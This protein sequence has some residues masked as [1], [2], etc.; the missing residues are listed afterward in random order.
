MNGDAHTGALAPHRLAAGEKVGA[1]AADVI[2]DQADEAERHGD[3][4]DDA[5]IEL[6]EQAQGG[7][8]RPPQEDERQQEQERQLEDDPPE[9]RRWHLL[10]GG[11]RVR[12][13]DRVVV[14]QLRTDVDF[15]RPQPV[16][17]E[18]NHH[19]EANRNPVA[20]AC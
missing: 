19:Q 15:E 1:Q 16:E 2:L 11:R 10:L 9:E 3:G 5:Q 17:L 13:C 7:H 4:R 18:T 20:D 12:I 14:R 6:G 8:A